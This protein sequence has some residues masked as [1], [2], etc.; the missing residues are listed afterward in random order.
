M[1]TATT[2]IIILV[3]TTARLIVGVPAIDLTVVVL[4]AIILLLVLMESI[5]TSKFKGD[6]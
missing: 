5:D 3:K 6:G 1:L 2:V 4:I